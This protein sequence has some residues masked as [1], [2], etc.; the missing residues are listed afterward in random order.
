MSNAAAKKP[1]LKPATEALVNLRIPHDQYTEATKKIRRTHALAGTVGSGR[2][3]MGVPGVGKTSILESYLREQIEGRTDLESET[4]SKEPVLYV[5]IPSAP[6]IRSLLPAILEA[7]RFHVSTSGRIKDLRE[8][9]DALIRNRGVELIIFDEF[10]H[11][12]REQAQI[13]TRNV[14]NEIKGIMDKHKLAVVMAGPPEGYRSIAKHEELYQRLAQE[15]IRLDP[16]SVHTDEDK[17]YFANYLA[18]CRKLLTQHEVSIFEMRDEIVLQRFYLATRGIP[19]LITNLF[20]N[21]LE[22]SD[23]SKPLTLKTFGFY[24]GSLRLN[25]DLGVFNP[26]TAKPEALA[27]RTETAIKERRTAERK[28]WEIK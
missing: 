14:V 5:P 4:L 15:P 24:Y 2:L 11:F 3:L 20:W 1:D 18:S 7:S 16:F 12:L 17:N 9:V 23:L 26:F 13:S 28:L 25:P 10:Q 8:K 19:R 27:G 21:V 22:Q 6:T